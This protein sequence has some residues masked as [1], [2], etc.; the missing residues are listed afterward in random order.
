MEVLRCGVT[1]CPVCGQSTTLAYHNRRRLMMLGGAV[2]YILK[3][4]QCRDAACPRHRQPLRPEAEGALALPR[5][6]YGLD[7]LAL[8]GRERYSEHRSVPEI[9]ALLLERGVEISERNVTN[10]LHRYEE[11]LA[12]RL[13]D[14][15]RLQEKLRAQGRVILALDG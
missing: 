4:R 2:Q 9:H 12:L 8:I 7:V 10:L 15:T 5:S 11:L 6:E 14:A 13:T 1:S 3:I